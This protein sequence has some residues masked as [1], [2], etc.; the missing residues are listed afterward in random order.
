MASSE[1]FLKQLELFLDRGP[2][3]AATPLSGGDINEA[4][5]LDFANGEALFL[6]RNSNFSLDFFEAEADGLKAL[7]QVDGPSTP[8]IIA[9]DTF[10]DQSFLLLEFLDQGA[11][12]DWLATGRALAQLHQNSNDRFGWVKDNYIGSLAQANR[13]SV[14]WSEFYAEYRLLTQAEKAFDRGFLNRRDLKS[15]ESLLREYP[16]LHPKEKPALLHGDLW[17]GNLLFAE[18]GKPYFIDPSVYYGHREMD[19]AM[20]QLFGG[21]PSS[22]FEVYQEHYPLES[23]WQ[24]RISLHQLYPLLV[25]L[26]LF[27][28]SYYASCQAVWQPFS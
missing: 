28:P 8:Q 21:F 15:L 17:S 7:H 5:R 6:K 27:G 3:L 22:V 14:D 10:N 18:G 20:M 4:F 24:A 1:S 26:N 25:H 11:E 16:H 12:R 9:L 2:I 19:L 13:W 23:N